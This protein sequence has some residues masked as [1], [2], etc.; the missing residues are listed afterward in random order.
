MPV[1]LRIT[2]L[3]TLL[4]FI[5]LALVCGA[6]YYVSSNNRLNS[7]RTR[8]TNR[9]ITTARLLSQ[10]E[11][12]DRDLVRR[13]DEATTV[14]LKDKTVQAYDYRNQRVYRYSEQPS[15][16]LHVGKEILDEAR[17]SDKV[18]FNWGRKEAVAYHYADNNLRMVVVAGAVDEEGRRY[19]R[20]LQVILLLCAM[21]G[22]IIALASGYFFSRGLLR[23]VQQIAD[24]VNEI[25]AQNFTRRIETG[26]V[27][28]EWYYLSDT[29]NRLLSRLKESFELQRHFISNA[30]HELSTPL[31]SIS[32]QLEV[33]LQR[34]RDPEEY[35]RVMQSVY[36]DVRHMSKLTQTLLEFAQASGTPG[37]LEIARVRLDE[38]LLRLPGELAKLDPRY[39]VSLNFMELPAEEDDLLV[40]GNEELL[41]SALK[42]IAVNACKYSSNHRA[43]VA[44]AVST[45]ALVITIRDRGIGIPPEEL[46]HIFHPFYRVDESRTTSGF[47]LGLSLA[48]RIVKLHK[49]SIE[50]ESAPGKGTLFTVELPSAMAFSRQGGIREKEL[51]LIQTFPPSF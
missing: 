39:T 42:N 4:V 12:F 23:P 14:A 15:D 20:Q 17:V 2:F 19:L 3:F 8:L 44:L 40:L 25:T 6:V 26:K 11:V 32:S 22:I 37:G 35:R 47:G 46:E 38:L 9:A 5:L 7:V 13:I 45:K 27:R 28:D 33:S 16:T 34:D 29:L 51:G 49:G 18:Y 21:G 1:R 31:T 30:S 48:H 36:Q 41:F 10:S 50:V 24:D 43:E